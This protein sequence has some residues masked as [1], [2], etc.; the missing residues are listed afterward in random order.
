MRAFAFLMIFFACDDMAIGQQVPNRLRDMNVLNTVLI[1]EP[2]QSLGPRL[3]RVASIFVDQCMGCHNDQQAE[4]GYSMATPESMRRA[5]DSKQLP[6]RQDP[7]ADNG[8]PGNEALG[9]LYRRLV[10]AD[11]S[12]RMPKDS[13]PLD[14]DS[15]DA[16]Y[17]WIVFGGKVDGANDAPI[18]S[19]VPTRLNLEP[20]WGTYPKPHA[21]SAIA[22]D[23]AGEII[24]SSGASEVLA[25][26]IDGKLRARIPVRGR[27]IS[28]I[29]WNEANSSLY[30]AS[31]T[32]GQIGIVE[33]VPWSNDE[34][35]TDTSRTDE[36]ARVVHWIARD[37]PLDIALSPDGSRLAIGLQDGMILV[38]SSHSNDILWK[39]ATH[40]A[41]VTSL[42]WSA[43]GKQLVSSSRDRTAKSLDA[44]NGDVIVSFVDHERTVSSVRSLN[45]GCVTMDEAGVLRVYPGGTASQ[46]ASSRKG[47][48]QRT[49]KLVSNREQV[50]MPIEGAVLRFRIRTKGVEFKDKEG[51]D[52]K[53]TEWIIDEEPRLTWAASGAGETDSEIPLVLA[54]SNS[55]LGFIAA[56]L[57]DGRI[58]VWRDDRSPPVSLWNQVPAAG[59]R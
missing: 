12:E 8:V 36:S 19:F 1:V 41:A 26:S 21:V 18:E 44:A 3:S 48:A 47:F 58:L 10:S 30:I 20:K 14:P 2:P 29:E 38:Q 37:L 45:A 50:L 51:K 9:E 33:S 46:S 34:S 13:P 52:K 54:M 7:N 42:D 32:P 40:A 49:P 55:D 59:I 39:V 17:D 4:G 24:F 31:G 16:I 15:V 28:D 57:A 5:G 22:I 35:R 25:W 56:G 27:F 6:I 53:K 23:R 11:P 43:D